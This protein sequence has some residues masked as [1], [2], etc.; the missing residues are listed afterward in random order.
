[1][2]V[3]LDARIEEW[4]S[5]LL[6]TSKR[7]RLISLSLGRAGAVKLVHPDTETLWSK[8]VDEGESVSFPKRLYLVGRAAEGVIEDESEEFLSLLDAETEEKSPPDRIDLQ[9]CLSSPRLRPDHVLTELTDKLLKSRLGRLDLNAKTSMT[10]QGVP[11]LHVAF[12]LLKW[13]ESPDSQVQIL[14]PLLLLP[15]EMERENIDS[16]WSLK[17]MEDEVVPNHSLAQLMSNNFSIRF[18]E[19]PEAEDADQEAENCS[20]RWRHR[21]YAGIQNVIRHQERWEIL[22]ECVAGHLQLSE[23]RHVG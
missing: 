21:Y 22:D 5:K 19:L 14:S 9:T 23:D 2:T 1:M 15:A 17:L 4:R 11:T 7:N 20:S 12:G 13:Y 3:P 6:D 8:L 16:P 10:E 18:P